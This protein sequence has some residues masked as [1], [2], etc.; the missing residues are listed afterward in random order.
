MGGDFFV[1]VVSD[2][3]GERG[4]GGGVM[5]MVVGV[6]FIGE[7]NV[8]VVLGVG[9]GVGMEG[10]KKSAVVWGAVVVGLGGWASLPWFLW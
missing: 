1:E 8:E 10:E 4:T 2:V 3:D 9:S 5:I 6:A 7:R